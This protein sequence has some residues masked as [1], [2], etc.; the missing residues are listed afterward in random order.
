[1]VALVTLMRLWL[2]GLLGPSGILP[3]SCLGSVINEE[4]EREGI[5]ESVKFLTLKA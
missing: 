1:M 2:L 5:M 3:G 4:T